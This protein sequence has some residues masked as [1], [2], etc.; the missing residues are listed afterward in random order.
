MKVPWS[1]RGRLLADTA[2]ADDFSV[3]SFG[4]QLRYR[5]E[6]GPQSEFYLVYS[7]GGEERRERHDDSGDLFL[8]ALSLRDADQVLAKLR[9]RF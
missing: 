7:R 8:D 3:N 5:H 9:Y 6:L 4:V 1:L 2:G